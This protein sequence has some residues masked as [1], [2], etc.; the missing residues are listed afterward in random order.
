MFPLLILCPEYGT[1][2]KRGDDMPRSSRQK[3]KILYLAQYL[4]EM[5]DEEHPATMAELLAALER[6]GI[7]SERKSIYADL[8]E[9]RSFG[10]DVI[11]TRSK[12]TGYFIGERTFQLPEV[13]L[14]VDA[15][16]SSRFLTRKK[17]EE[18]IGKLQT[19]LS[20]P[21]AKSVSHTV[22]V[23]GRIKTMNESIYRNVDAI[24]HAIE[25]NKKLSFFYFEWD[26]MGQKRFRRN[27]E[28]YVVSPYF[29]VWDDEN[30]YLVALDEKSG[31]KR[32]FRV[33][34]MQTISALDQRRSGEE[35]FRDFD[36]AGFEKKTFGMFGGTEERV[37]LWC[38]ES[39]SGVFFD[40]FGSTLVTRSAP[41]G[42]EATVSVVVSPMFFSWLASFGDRVR[43]LSPHRVRATYL[44]HLRGILDCYQEEEK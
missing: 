14:L 34:K 6:Q 31:E 16:Q 15:V 13:R 23:A 2:K 41:D 43:I 35:I 32:H 5:T 12:T 7:S 36:P 38:H 37:S 11:Q 27:G 1:M 30:Y 3:Q 4:L 10:L 40:R 8:E 9:L 33:D 18:L 20:K 29:L 21:S 42:F 24:S 28:A 25:E 19:L 26:Q 44:D 39:L 17:S 22:F